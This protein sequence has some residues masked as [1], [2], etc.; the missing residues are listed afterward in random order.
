MSKKVKIA[1]GIVVVIAVAGIIFASIKKKDRGLKQVTTGVVE[2]ADLVS[3]V[4]ANGRIEAKRKVDRILRHT[5]GHLPI[6]DFVRIGLSLDRYHEALG[7]LKP[8]AIVQP[9]G[10]V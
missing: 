1:I 9:G 2:T 3:K 5:P 7:W 10:G 4:S 6:E 8:S